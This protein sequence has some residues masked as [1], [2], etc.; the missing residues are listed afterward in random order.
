MRMIGPITKCSPLAALICTHILT[1]VPASAVDSPR[2][3]VTIL[4]KE[5]GK[6]GAVAILG[7]PDGLVALSIDGKQR[8][9]LAQGRIVDVVVDNRSDVIWYASEGAKAASDRYLI[10]LRAADI[11]PVR[12]MAGLGLGEDPDIAYENPAEI[13]P[14]GKSNYVLLLA[15]SGAV[16]RR[17]VDTCGKRGGI[18]CPK[19]EYRPCESA[20]KE[21]QCPSL[22]SAAL[23]LL[24]SLAKRGAGRSLFLPTQKSSVTKHIETKDVACRRCGTASGIP[25]TNYWSVLTQVLGDACHVVTQVFDPETSQF[26]DINSGNHSPRPFNDPKATFGDAWI[27]ADGGAFIETG[28]IHTFA[29]GKL[30]WRGPYEG[31]GFLG[32][33]WWIPDSSYPCEH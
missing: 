8:R 23:S 2:P 26:I 12:I 14:P 5:I 29:A 27:A 18:G 21:G 30:K 10:D 25:G 16:V 19:V 28:A 24:Q 11:R 33:G 32:G 17:R 3:L 22:D 4:Q 7:S 9:T 6:G 1:G 15:E 31:G 20:S 13:S